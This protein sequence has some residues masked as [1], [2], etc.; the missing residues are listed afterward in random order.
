MVLRT[1]EVT[2]SD[3]IKLHLIF[4]VKEKETLW[5]A[6]NDAT[7]VFI[8]IS[9]VFK[10]V[11]CPEAKLVEEFITGSFVGE[12]KALMNESPLTTTVKAMTDGLIYKIAKDD[13]LNYLSKNPGILVNF[14]ENK[15]II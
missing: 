1:V 11:L 14:A 9:G 15:Y 2:S 12:V 3:T 4:Q 6:G 13:I 5:T 10:F 7:F 8:V